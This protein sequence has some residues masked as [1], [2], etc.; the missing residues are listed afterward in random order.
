MMNDE[1]EKKAKDKRRKTK[2]KSAP[3]GKVLHPVGY[4]ELTLNAER[5]NDE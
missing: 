3:A 1:S 2:V 4:L 5:V